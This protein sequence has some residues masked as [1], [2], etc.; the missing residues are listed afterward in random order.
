MRGQHHR[1]IIVNS[2]LEDQV[3]HRLE[4]LA[5]GAVASTFEFS[6]NRVTILMHPEE[7]KALGVMLIES[8]AISN[9]LVIPQNLKAGS[10]VV[11][12]PGPP[13]P[14]PAASTLPAP[15]EN[16]VSDLWKR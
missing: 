8:A 10:P 12:L 3:G 11:A 1:S 13:A 5:D 4:V 6:G 9:R 14:H 16:G 2:R 7:A 15:P